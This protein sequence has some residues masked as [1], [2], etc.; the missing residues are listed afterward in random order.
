MSFLEA[1]EG[2]SNIQEAVAYTF[3]TRPNIAIIGKLN[4]LVEE[5]NLSIDI[6]KDKIN[7]ELLLQEIT[8]TGT[9][10]LLLSSMVNET[11]DQ[12]NEAQPPIV[13][14]ESISAESKYSALDYSPAIRIY[15]VDRSSASSRDYIASIEAHYL[16]REPLAA[17]AIHSDIK[18]IETLTFYTY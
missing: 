7:T 11:L 13:V 15:L 9:Q 12:L 2:S 16:S 1:I 8:R 3:N 6:Q 14:Y 10:T 5:S 18:G 4:T 17:P